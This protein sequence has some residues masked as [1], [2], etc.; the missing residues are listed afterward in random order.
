MLLPCFKEVKELTVE[1]VKTPSVVR[2]SGEA[3]CARRIYGFYSGLEYFRQHPAQL[4]LQRTV[5]DDIERFNVLAMVR[6]TQGDSRRAVILLGHIDT[7]GVEDF[8]SLR[9][10]AWDP[11]TLEGLLRQMDL[12]EEVQRDL[13]SGEYLFGRGALDMKSGVAGQMWLVRYFAEHPE[14]LNGCLIAIAECDE[15]DNSRGIISALKVL[16]QW[17]EEHGLEYIAAINAD[18]STPYHELDD[19]RYVYCGTIGK[20]LP[21]FYVVGRETHA[22]QPFGGLN[23]NLVTA[24][25]TRLIELDPALCDEAQGEVTMPPTCLKQADLKG[26]YDVQT[27]L[28]AYAYYNVFMHSLGPGEVLERMKE[29][30]VTAFEN[31]IDHVNACYKAYCQRSGHPY[32]RLPWKGRVYTWAEFYREL[33]QH[34][35]EG[36]EQHLK[37]F[38]LKLQQSRPAL[39]LRELNLRIV[40]EAWQWAPDQNPAIIVFN[41]STYFSRVEVTGRTPDEE[42]LLE[43]VKAA[44]AEVQEH[45]DRPI[46]TKMFYPYISDASFMSLGGEQQELEELAEN[47]PAWGSGYTHPVDDIA[48]INVPVVNIGS[49]G[50]DGHKLTERVH[51]RHTFEIVPN[52]TYRTVKRLLD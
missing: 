26:A 17:K 4:I 12:R 8:G 3:E 40:E 10:H 44:V 19:N 29:K 43:S 6:G 51:M 45:S 46:V 14:E 28:A 20:L 16:K 35:G 32:T 21:T 42:R 11:E 49:F 13:D 25:L 50:K 34:H 36:F 37:Q 39:D 47:T 22:G 2:T 18:Y 41:S 31:V 30:A 24:E 48:A 52:I 5:E 7:V 9:E 33:L 1:L 27:P 23:P 15:E 38:T